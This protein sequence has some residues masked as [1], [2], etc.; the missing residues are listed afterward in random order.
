MPEYAG[1]FR[2][3]Q[4]NA[5][6]M[7]FTNKCRHFSNPVIEAAHVVSLYNCVGIDRSKDINM[8]RTRIDVYGTLYPNKCLYIKVAK[9]T[10]CN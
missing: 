4:E 7:D 6:G 2:K 10:M 8:N 3:I 5:S 1:L 9:L